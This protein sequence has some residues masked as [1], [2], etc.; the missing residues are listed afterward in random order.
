[1]EKRH[2]H[3]S[4]PWGLSTKPHLPGPEQGFCLSRIPANRPPYAVPMAT[5]AWSS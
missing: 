4:V 5:Q 3:A 1:M 2:S